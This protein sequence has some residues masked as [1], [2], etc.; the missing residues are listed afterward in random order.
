M[1][2]LAVYHLNVFS[3]L[4]V[5][6]MQVVQMYHLLAL[7]HLTRSLMTETVLFALQGHEAAKNTVVY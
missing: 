3:C 1:Y 5:L 4:L 6:M 7:G 2:L